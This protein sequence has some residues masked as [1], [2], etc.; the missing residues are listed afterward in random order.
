[1][2]THI[3]V[4][5]LVTLILNLISS[6]AS[7]G[8]E[9]YLFPWSQSVGCPE[10]IARANAM[11]IL[12][13]EKVPASDA[14]D[15]KM[16]YFTGQGHWYDLA[17]IEGGIDSFWRGERP[18]DCVLGSKMT[19][20][21]IVRSSTPFSLDQ[22]SGGVTGSDFWNELG[23]RFQGLQYSISCRGLSYGVDGKKDTADDRWVT[24]G[25]SSQK[26]NE[27]YYVGFW[28]AH[29]IWSEYDLGNLEE[30]VERECLILTCW[31]KV[32]VVE[33]QIDVP[34]SDYYR[35]EVRLGISRPGPYLVDLK[36][37]APLLNQKLGVLT[38]PTVL[39]PWEPLEDWDAPLGLWSSGWYRW[40]ATDKYQFF[41]LDQ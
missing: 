5:V 7:A 3:A 11:K 17:K 12:L 14:S 8:V 24:D 38:A 4:A 29:N 25:L 41:R 27:I 16:P 39:G 37:D 30:W 34:M 35:D 10:P 9:I 18:Q 33:A 6:T 31:F 15:P 21:V 23:F 13:G 2:K 1:M 40:E 28:V 32:G 26:V 22:V 36:I 19:C 20:A